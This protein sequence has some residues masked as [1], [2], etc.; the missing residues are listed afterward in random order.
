M[1]LPVIHKNN[2]YQV[3][4]DEMFAAI[5]AGKPI[6]NGEAAAHST[7]L[8]LM[9]R[10]AAY[11]GQTITPE[12]I[13]NS[14]KTSARPATSSGRSPCLR[15]RCPAVRDLPENSVTA[16]IHCCWTERAIDLCPA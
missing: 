8:A 11:T 10:T 5:R 1:A 3:E 13:L 14:K 12:T 9:G 4:H 6:N 2:M 16:V 15:S 7:L